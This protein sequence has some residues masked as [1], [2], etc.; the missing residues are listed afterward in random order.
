M[1]AEL[2]NRTGHGEPLVYVPGIDGS[3]D[4]L[5]GTEQ[6]LARSSEVITL[7]Y[8]TDE[9]TPTHA[10]LA[11]SIAQLL[12]PLGLG[13]S[14]V[15]AESFGVAVAL[16]LALDFPAVVGGLMLVNGFARYE[17]RALLALSRAFAPLV[18]PKL[19]A[20]GKPL[21]ARLG[22]FGGR[23]DDA[24]LDVFLS[25]ASG[26]I[27]L[28]YRQRLEMIQHVNLLPRLHEIQQ[29]VAI[30]ASDRDRVVPS[31]RAGRVMAER[32][33]DATLEILRGAGHI[34]LP[35]EGEPWPE[36]VEA[37]RRRTQGS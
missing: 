17:N 6:R 25:T 37:L 11:A 1:H 19:F 31:I 12:E 24:A 3:G 18:T 15:L 9:E 30:F 5:L 27:D 33:P 29:P 2:R 16:Q 26:G 35:L 23:R 21:A 36:R 32:L 7:R 8:A 13:P 4:Y 28:G 22:L 14:L 10:T 20:L 34:V